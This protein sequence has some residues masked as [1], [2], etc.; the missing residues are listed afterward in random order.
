MMT[1]SLFATLVGFRGKPLAILG[2]PSKWT[3]PHPMVTDL[4]LRQKSFQSR[5]PT[6]IFNILNQTNT[7]KEIWDNVE[8]L[9]QGSEDVQQTGD[10]MKITSLQFPISAEH[11]LAQDILVAVN[12]DMGKRL[13]I[14]DVMCGIL[15][16][17]L[18][19]V[20][21]NLSRTGLEAAT[22]GKLEVRFQQNLLTGFAAALAFIVTGAVLKAENTVVDK[23]FSYRISQVPTKSLIDVVKKGFTSSCVLKSI[24]LDVLANSKDNGR[25]RM[26]FVLEC[27]NGLQDYAMADL[28][29]SRLGAKDSSK[30]I[31]LL[32]YPL[33]TERLDL[34]GPCSLNHVVFEYP[35]QRERVGHSLF[36]IL[37]FHVLL[38][39]TCRCHHRIA[40]D[41]LSKYGREVPILVQRVILSPLIFMRVRLVKRM[42]VRWIL[43]CEDGNQ[44]HMWME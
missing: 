8:M 20:K 1:Y 37:G 19:S 29:H 31:L 32:R 23:V 41:Y 14:I 15:I 17:T 27:W 24:T 4:Q 7:A 25:D 33:T 13:V 38:M 39:R 40:V 42:H 44:H 35:F 43:Y 10:D 30:S 18:A 2:T 34:D 21:R 6:Y 16:G 3:V 11:Q 36:D 26:C 28:D 22:T 5:S 9:M 12:L